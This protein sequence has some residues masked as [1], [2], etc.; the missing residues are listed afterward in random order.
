MLCSRALSL[1]AFS[2]EYP[3]E[4]ERAKGEAV[5]QDIMLIK[6][7]NGVWIDPKAVTSVGKDKEKTNIIVVHLTGGPMYFGTFDDQ[8]KMVDEIATLVNNSIPS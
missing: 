6:L 3:G 5:R 4:S 8:Q 2:W 1:P 7:S